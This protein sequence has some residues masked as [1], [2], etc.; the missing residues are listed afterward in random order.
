VR[1]FLR[2]KFVQDLFITTFTNI[3]ITVVGAISGIL[4]A[5]LLGPDGRGEL[6]MALVW[7]AILGTVVQTG[8][9]QSLIYF[10]A[11]QREEIGRIFSTT[12]V[13]VVLQSIVGIS[14]GWYVASQVLGRSQPASLPVV[15]IYLLS[16]PFAMMTTYLSAMAQGLGR[17]AL[18][19]SLRIYQTMGH[20]I[21]LLV[22][23]G[24]GSPSPLLVVVLLLGFQ[25][26]VCAIG[27]ILFLRQVR[28][29]WQPAYKF[30]L[31]LLKYGI[32]SYWGGLGWTVNTRLD[33]FLMS[34]LLSTREL[35]LYAVGVSYATV[36]F[37]I[38]GAFA[39][40]TF[41]HVA[42][43]GSKDAPVTIFKMLG[44]N[45]VITLP[46]SVLAIFLSP[47]LLPLLFGPQFQEAAPA[48][49][50]LLIG[51]VILGCNYVLSDGLRGWGYPL[52]PSIAEL[53]GVGVT[54]IGLLWVLKPLGI[55]GAA[56]VSVASY[57]L[58]LL[59]L[60]SAPFYLS[61]QVN[62]LRHKQVLKNGLK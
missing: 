44:W 49:A 19:N 25:M 54:V 24:L 20:L 51:A 41:P 60:I 23:E 21:S 35:G 38:S 52:I 6:A 31:G 3:G 22:A 57:S 46:L 37:Q 58:T 43:T 32:E 13:L 47:K 12:I 8:L 17:F 9:A 62:I 34:I 11:G 5:R 2:G 16:I 33:Q 14:L 59:V 48:T 40:I 1:Q 28:P 7:A 4:A 36:L 42:G 53:L 26:S 30:A 10:A 45:L 29:V 18:F 61:R 55:L 56:W 27:L 15:H 39:M 50:I